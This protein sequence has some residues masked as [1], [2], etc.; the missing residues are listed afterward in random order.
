MT[1]PIFIFLVLFGLPAV[2]L[3]DIAPPDT[4]ATI[5]PVE[6]T[7]EYFDRLD[8]LGCTELNAFAYREIPRYVVADRPDLLYELALYWEDRCLVTE[9]IFRIK[10]LGSIWDAAFDEGLYGSEALDRLIERYDPP[11][12]SKHPDLR[13]AFDKFSASFADQLLPHVPRGSLEEFY[14]LYYKGDT[15]KAWAMLESEDLE[16]TWLRYYYDEEIQYLTRTKT[17]P[18][19]A[20][21]GGGWWPSGNV[22]FVGDKPLVGFLSGV[23]WPHWLLRFV[24]EVR[25]GRSDEPYWVDEDGFSGRS[26]RFDAILLG[27]EFGR[28]L[29]KS[30]RHNVDVFVGVGFD[31]V[32]PFQDEDFILSTINANLGLGYRF[33]A[34]KDRN[35]ILGVDVRHEWIGERNESTA[36]MSGTALSARFSFGFA[37][38][39]G[40]DRRLE[41]LGR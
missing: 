22:E 23:R 3:A 15:A 14:C 1:R 35:W 8:Q 39:E 30:G 37:F 38:N 9:P 31:G 36:S 2:A 18:T 25:V 41:S 26:D 32:K 4:T 19:L 28:I 34:G 6:L 16:D 21:T 5:L 11:V 13:E 24:F 12:K 10:V 33:F 29:Y 7:E 17:V 40:R 20:I 27:G